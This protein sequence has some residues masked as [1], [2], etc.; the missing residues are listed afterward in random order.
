MAVTIDR[1]QVFAIRYPEPNNDGK[2]GPWPSSA[3]S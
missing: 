1:I 3:W 2:S